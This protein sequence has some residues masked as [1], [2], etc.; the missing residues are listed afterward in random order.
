MDLI[1]YPGEMDDRRKASQRR[2]QDRMSKWRRK[3]SPGNLIFALPAWFVVVALAPFF[4]ATHIW[5]WGYAPGFVPSVHPMAATIFL[6][7]LSVSIW[8]LTRSH[9]FEEADRAEGYGGG[10]FVENRLNDPPGE[11]Y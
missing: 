3:F 11:T 4:V 5:G 6:V 2:A 8:Y 7:V 9:T 10:A 1:G